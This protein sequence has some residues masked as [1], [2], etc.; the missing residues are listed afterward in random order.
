[1]NHSSPAPAVPEA[2]NDRDQRVFDAVRELMAEQGMDLS[3]EALALRAGC[4]KQTL[5]SRYG[6]KQELLR[7]VLHEH[8]QLL[9]SPLKPDNGDIRASLVTFAR[10]HLRHL[11]RPE[12]VQA[13]Q[14]IAAE[15]RRFPAAAQEIYRNG[16]T[17]LQRQLAQWLAAASARGLLRH[18]D[19]HFMAEL[20]LSMIVGLDFERQRFRIPHRMDDQAI[21][22]WAEFSV[23]S[24][25]RAFAPAA[26]TAV[27]QSNQ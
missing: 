1:M 3:M 22:A 25:M 5:Y 26:A 24:F 14:L 4:S 8:L 12:V 6:S 18:D 7:R 15:A 13:S 2:P 16:V 23:D 20:L 9:T 19:P 10:G 17:T 27:T 21:Q 11:N